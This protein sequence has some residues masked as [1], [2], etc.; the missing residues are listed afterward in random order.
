MDPNVH[1]PKKAIK[2]N[3]SLT[4]QIT[5][6]YWNKIFN[7]WQATLCGISKGSFEI[8]HKNIYTSNE[9]IL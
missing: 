1:S 8:A 3:H 7:V 5:S 2:L 4:L 9:K 6:F